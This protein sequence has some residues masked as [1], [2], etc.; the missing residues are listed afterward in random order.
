MWAL[1]LSFH[2]N[3]DCIGAH[4]SYGL[5][6]HQARNLLSMIKDAVLSICLCSASGPELGK[7]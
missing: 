6:L 3:R 7:G 4:A 2:T 5:R 1:I